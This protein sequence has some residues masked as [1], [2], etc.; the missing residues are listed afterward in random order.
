MTNKVRLRG[1]LLV[2][3]VYGQLCATLTAA[4]ILK[5]VAVCVAGGLRI[6]SLP[7][8]NGTIVSKL[9]QGE[10]AYILAVSD[11]PQSIEGLKASW[12]RVVTMSGDFGWALGGYLDTAA[13][14][15]RDFFL[16]PAMDPEIAI[17]D[18][19]GGFENG[20]LHQVTVTAPEVIEAD[21]WDI[22]ELL[23]F[24]P[25]N[26]PVQLA[27]IDATGEIYEEIYRDMGL[28]I[29]DLIAGPEP[30]ISVITSEGTSDGSSSYLEI[31]GVASEDQQYSYLGSI[32]TGEYETGDV[33]GASGDSIVEGPEAF[34]EG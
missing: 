28:H 29:E 13:V 8:L 27:V 5:N 18:L 33:C 21:R 31:Y 34:G 15:P 9:S 3:A 11:E 23:Y 25:E 7:D 17:K 6:R 26:G 24:I 1:I 4:P 22:R 19:S 20:R 12:Y 32:S 14:E 30:E 10:E 16:D 2:I